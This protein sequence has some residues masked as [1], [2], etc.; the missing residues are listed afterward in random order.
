MN[1]LL[2]LPIQHGF[3]LETRYKNNA[4]SQYECSFARDGQIEKQADRPEERSILPRKLSGH[5]CG[6]H[7]GTISKKNEKKSNKQ[8]HIHQRRDSVGCG[9]LIHS[10]ESLV[11]YRP[12]I[13]KQQR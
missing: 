2:C 1:I 13:K 4:S 10:S 6:R 5:H 8:Q 12:G 11:F 7:V 9:A 3:T